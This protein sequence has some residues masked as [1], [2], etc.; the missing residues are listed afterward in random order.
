MKKIILLTAIA[1]TTASITMAQRSGKT[2]IS[3]GPELGIAT[4]NPLKDLPDNKGWGLGL[5]ASVQVEHFFQQ[6]VSGLLYAG[7]I[8]YT[9][10]SSGSAVK[11]KA[12]TA[13]PIRIGGNVYAGSNLHFGAQLGVGLNNIGGISETA[14]SYSPQIGYNFKNRN[15]KPLDLTVKYD[16][17]AGHRNFSALGLRLSLI[18]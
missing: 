14:F 15:D 16:G 1:L 4:S 13:I 3:I 6:N 11:N 5:G 17:Y 12:Y 8:G 7:L 10:R 2:R 9:G 18:L